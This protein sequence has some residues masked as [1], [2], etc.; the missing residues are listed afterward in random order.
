MINDCKRTISEIKEQKSDLGRREK[1]RMSKWLKTG[2]DG[3][4]ARATDL[5]QGQK[6]TKEVEEEEEPCT[7]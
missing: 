3:E 6:T 7:H 4:S 1:E 2:S 5:C